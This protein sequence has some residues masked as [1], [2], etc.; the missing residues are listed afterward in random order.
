MRAKRPAR[1]GGGQSEASESSFNL[2]QSLAVCQCE[3]SDPRGR[4][5]EGT[6][7][8]SLSYGKVQLFVN[9]T[10]RPTR[11]GVGEWS[12]RIKYLLVRFSC[13]STRPSD[14]RGGGEGRVEPKNQ[15]YLKGVKYSKFGHR[16]PNWPSLGLSFIRNLNETTNPLTKKSF[17]RLDATKRSA[18]RVQVWSIRSLVID[19]AIGLSVDFNL[20]KSQGD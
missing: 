13:W 1:W 17:D 7:E 16:L 8:L 3:P 19:Q 4:G 15:V 11:L 9:A 12:L 5:G 18:W 14:P 2:W 10:K 20:Q 6:Y